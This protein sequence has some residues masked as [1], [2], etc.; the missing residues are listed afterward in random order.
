MVAPRCFCLSPWEDEGALS[1]DNE[2]VREVR[3]RFGFGRVA[4]ETPS[5]PLGGAAASVLT[6]LT[7][8]TGVCSLTPELG[9]CQ[10]HGV[11]TR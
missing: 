4:S 7:P 2:A 8:L 10:A 9:R 1:R 3:Y 11:L 5:G 6:P